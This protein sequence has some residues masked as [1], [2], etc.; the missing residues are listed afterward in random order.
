MRRIFIIGYYNHKNLGDEQYKETFKIVFE[1]YLGMRSP[2][3]ID[4]DKIESYSFLDSDLIILGGGD[5]LHPYFIRKIRNT[6]QSRSNQV[7]AFSVGIPYPDI[8]LDSSL[9]FLDSI[10][11]RTFQDIQ[12]PIQIP[13]HYVPDVSYFLTQRQERNTIPSLE[14][15]NKKIIALTL[16]QNIYH[17]SFQT[18]YNTCVCGFAQLVCRCI[19]SGFFVLLV[20]FN[21]HDQA[22][23]ENDKVLHKEI[24]G[25]IPDRFRNSVLNIDLTLTAKEMMDL[26][27]YI[28]MIIPMRYHSVLFSI[29]SGVPMVPVYT[30]RKVENLLRDTHWD[31]SYP[32]PKNKSDIPTGIDVEHILKQVKIIDTHYS[33]YQQ[34]LKRARE[35]CFEHKMYHSLVHLQERI[36]Q[37]ST[38]D[39]QPRDLQPRDLQT[40]KWFEQ[41]NKAFNVEDIR[42]LESSKQPL[43]VQYIEYLLT[44]TFDTP[45]AHGL[46]TK[47][48]H[49]EYN[50][51]K[52]WDWV[53]KDFYLN[54]S[55]RLGDNPK[56]W[57]NLNQI[58]SNRIVQHNNLNVHRFGW[59]YVYEHLKPLHN[60]QCPV[61]LDLYVDRTFHWKQD[62][63]ALLNI[64][65]YTQPWVGFVHHTFDESFSNYNNVQL[66]ENPLF[67]ESL[68]V[69]KGLIVLSKFQQELWIEQLVKKGIHIPVHVLVHPTETQVM[70]F[71]YQKFI[72]QEQPK[73]VNIGGWL[74][75]VYAFYNLEC[76]ES[77]P[78][79]RSS[80]FCSKR[81]VHFQKVALKGPKMNNYYPPNF[82]LENLNTF[83]FQTTS[84]IESNTDF[85]SR[86]SGFVSRHSG[87]VSGHSF[88]N[89]WS[90]HFYQHISKQFQSLEIIDYLSNE[91]YDQLLSENIV[92]ICLVDASAVNTLIECIV[93]NTPILVNRHPA[94]EEL[95]GKNY[96]LYYNS[97]TYVQM[98]SS[99]QTLF[100]QP[101]I[102]W[103]AHRH[104]TRLDKPKFRIEHFIQ[105]LEQIFYVSH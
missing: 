11:I 98:N 17:P 94:V 101:R 26:Y 55:E 51:E 67:I 56:G 57:I 38:R 30:T 60:S 22:P 1:T 31:V 3:F 45:Y 29:Y 28:Y 15:F 91:A 13:V 61:F 72:Q 9:D 7:I 33:A 77:I 88:Q 66:L 75:D 34:K 99:I 52:E 90:K 97:T 41:V 63:N 46:Q 39:L 68:K 102:I 54:Y 19:Q 93:R 87:F 16:S 36:L 80:Y 43:A 100:K 12:I 24:Y 10:F 81:L 76:P 58:G 73:I 27:S 32:I 64:I 47:L 40:Q 6:F 5:I 83:L 74:R 79:H 8:L 86:H 62:I 25:L 85:V 71:S 50:Y 18:E 78:L 69:C 70:L 14:H 82:F 103:K 35:E 23:Y 44:G 105:E 95:L 65:P 2:M 42:T 96:P 53:Y 48:F 84:D 89:N 59:Q 92:F 49:S 37:Y 20:P 104:L 4:C 21:T